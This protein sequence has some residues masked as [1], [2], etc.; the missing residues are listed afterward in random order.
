MPIFT[1][2]VSQGHKNINL[3]MTEQKIEHLA[4]WHCLIPA[5]NLHFSYKAHKAR[6][7]YTLVDFMKL[8]F[9]NSFH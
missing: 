6:K 8:L 9:C 7:G 2:F 1:Y 4:K 3:S 5:T